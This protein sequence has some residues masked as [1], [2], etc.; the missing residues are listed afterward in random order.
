MNITIPFSKEILFK[1][2]IAE[3]TSISLEHDIS[4]NEK[5]LLGDFIVSGEYKNLDVNVD[6]NPFSHVVPFSVELKNNI[7]INTLKYE[8][9][10]FSYEIKDEDIL[11]INILFHV[12]AD[13]LSFKHEEIF[14]KPDEDLFEREIKEENKETDKNEITTD[15]EAEEEKLEER[16]NDAD[17]L[18]N[19]ELVEDYITYHIHLVKAGE[20]IKTISK[21]YNISEEELYDLNSQNDVSIGDKLLIPELDEEE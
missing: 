18:K 13:E 15:N 17:I 20:T 16:D 14:E 11:A 6:T 9:E 4:I 10:D 21:F 3:I 5:E 7:D 8:I 1:S 12:S 2:K 19:N